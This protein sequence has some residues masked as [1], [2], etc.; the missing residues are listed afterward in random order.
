MTKLTGERRPAGTAD[1]LS[2]QLSSLGASGM[3][4]FLPGSQDTRSPRVPGHRSRQGA[5]NPGPLLLPAS[6]C[7][8]RGQSPQTAVNIGF[9]RR[10]TSR[11]PHEMLS[12]PQHISFILI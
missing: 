6:S 11:H 4:L 5:R 12:A 3:R 7:R 10:L 2:E 8:R 9:G 1:A